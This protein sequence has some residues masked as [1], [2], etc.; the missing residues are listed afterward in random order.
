M[1]RA[2]SAGTPWE[3][4]HFEPNHNA[5]DDGS[6]PEALIEALRRFRAGE[7]GESDVIVVVRESRFLIPLLAH[8]GESGLND[9]GQLIDKTQ[10]LSIVTVI[11][12]DGRRVLPVFT[13]VAS[14][15]RWDSSARPVPADAVRIALAAASE[16]TDLVIIDP[17]SET[18]FVI[19][20]PAVWSIAQ[21]LQWTPCYLDE[22]VL[23]AFV[24]AAAGEPA[25]RSVALA[26]GDPAARLAG[27]ELVVQLALADGL[28]RPDL[29]ALLARLQERWATSEVIATR[30][31]SM[32]VQLLN[33]G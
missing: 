20:R 4:R 15:A 13:S 12:P 33:A 2:D 27:P 3:G 18:E 23:D 9:A 26:S 17:T 19:R 29:D 24:D 10:E 30:V 28:T 8:L 31:D 6:A 22:T 16:Q 25:L 7:I 32:R 11:A 21:S 14:M 5:D 1:S